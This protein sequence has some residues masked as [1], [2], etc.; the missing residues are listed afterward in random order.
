MVSAIQKVAPMWFARRFALTFLSIVAFSTIAQAFV[1]DWDGNTWTAETQSNSCDVP[2]AEAF[3]GSGISQIVGGS[4]TTA[5]ATNQ[6]VDLQDIAFTRVPEIN[7][8]WSAVV[9]CLAAAALILRHRA[10]LRK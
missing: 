4:D 9:S 7:P 3:S 10:N 6:N 2:G 1:L 8:A 5:Q